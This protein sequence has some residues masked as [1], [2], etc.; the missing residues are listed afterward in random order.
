MIVSKWA[1][2]V[3]ENSSME[4]SY[5]LA[6]VKDH[7]A[8]MHNWTTSW[9]DRPASEITRGEG[10]EV[11]ELVI[12]EGRTKSFQ[13]RLKNTINMIYSWAIEHRYIRGIHN[14]PVYGLK[15]HQK[16]EKRP[17]ILKVDEIRKLLHE[18][19]SIDHEWYPIW[20]MALL[21]GMRNGELYA[22]KWEDVDLDSNLITVQRSFNRRMNTF[23]STKAGYWRTVPIS[24]ELRALIHEIQVRSRTEFVLP[25]LVA[26]RQGYQARVLKTFCRSIGIPQVKFHTL[27]AC[28]ATQLIGSGIESVKVMKICG[29][30]DLKT[31]SVYLRLSGIDEKGTTEVL[32]ILPRTYKSKSEV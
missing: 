17:E 22:L 13:K 7:V 11:L 19:K 25:R 1:T 30:K 3:S 18:S 26:W 27:R 6:T 14:S 4:K 5:N 24:S 29:W 8:M 2:T 9:L 21:T 12:E 23:K 20:A 10:R 15:I 32:K 16:E 28:F 31:L